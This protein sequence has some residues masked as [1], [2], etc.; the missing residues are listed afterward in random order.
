[1]RDYNQ[2]FINLVNDAI[3]DGW[4]PEWID[5]AEGN[6]I[7]IYDDFIDNLQDSEEATC[8]FRFTSPEEWDIMLKEDESS[9][10][11]YE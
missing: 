4:H 2:E 7:Y 8:Y 6:N 9:H 5:R 10:W 3:K 11:R 1:M